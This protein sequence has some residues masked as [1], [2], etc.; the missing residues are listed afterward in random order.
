MAMQKPVLTSNRG[1]SAELIT[2]NQNGFLL[3]PYHHEEF[4]ACICGLLDDPDR[5]L[6]IGVQARAQVQLH[7]D[8]LHLAQQTAQFYE[9]LIQQPC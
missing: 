1:W 9:T 7:F 8:S 3:N 2:P 4:A 5:C 6:A